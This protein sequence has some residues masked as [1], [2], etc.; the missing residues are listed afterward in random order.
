MD[1]EKGWTVLRVIQTA[2]RSIPADSEAL[3]STP[4]GNRERY[5]SPSALRSYEA[6]VN[7]MLMVSRIVSEAKARGKAVG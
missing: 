5:N 1:M 6:G 7:R 4:N 3:S 2:S